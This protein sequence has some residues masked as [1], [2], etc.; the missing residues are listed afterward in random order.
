MGGD[1]TDLLDGENNNDTL[2]GLT[3]DDK[4]YGSE[5]KDALYGG[6]GN[7]SLN[8]GGG[9]DTL[10]GGTGN[11][12]F[13][14]DTV[15]ESAV[16]DNRDVIKDF[17]SGA[18]KIYVSGIQAFAFKGSASPTGP[19]Q[20]TLVNATNGDTI[21]QLNTDNDLEPESEIAIADGSVSASD[22]KD[23]DFILSG[24]GKTG[25]GVENIL[26]NGSFEEGTDPGV[27]LPLNPGSKGITDWEVTRGGIDYVGTDWVSSEGNRSIDL[28]GTP[29]VG[30]VAQAFTTTPGHKYDVS[31]DLAGHYS[32]LLQT[33]RVSAAGQSADFSFQSG[34]DPKQ[35]GWK[36]YTWDFTAKDPQTTIEF[37][38]LQTGYEYG[39]PALDNVVVT[40]AGLLLA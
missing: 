1:G 24:G 9:P 5:G 19:G 34:T 8:G 10:Y 26:R 15:S 6:D 29:G 2:E 18:D 37:S 25:G 11:D 28:N 36:E 27:Y 32:G 38:S 3:G 23:V 40:D 12:I 31:F 13:D 16:G 14:F 4:L 17:V 20:L 35:L 21:I 33:M 30:G 7:D 39:G 22:Y